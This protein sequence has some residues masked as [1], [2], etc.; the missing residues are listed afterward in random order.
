VT[1]DELPPENGKE[2]SKKNMADISLTTSPSYENITGLLDH[3]A[4]GVFHYLNL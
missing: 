3:H 4:V 2:G 1:W